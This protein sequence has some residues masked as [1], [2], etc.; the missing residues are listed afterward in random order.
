MFC[1]S[2][3]AAGIL[4]LNW[5]NKQLVGD[6]KH[7]VNRL[8]EQ[9]WTTDILLLKGHAEI[10]GNETAGRLAKEALTEAARLPEDTSMVTNQDI[11]QSSRKMVL[12]KW[13]RRWETAETGRELF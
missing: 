11:S 7:K 4:T 2:Q 8:A 12:S 13:Q 9:G 10:L 6:I 1:D 3:S 5:N